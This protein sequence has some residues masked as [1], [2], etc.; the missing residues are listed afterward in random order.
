MLSRAV[1]APDS[2]HLAS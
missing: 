2:Y 1:A